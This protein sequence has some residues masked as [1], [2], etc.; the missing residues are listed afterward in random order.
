MQDAIRAYYV[1][2]P[3]PVEYV[4]LPHPPLSVNESDCLMQIH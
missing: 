1:L 3:C 4:N 2:Q